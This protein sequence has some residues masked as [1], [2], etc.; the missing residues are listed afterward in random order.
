MKVAGPTTLPAL[1]ERAN[2]LIFLYANTS[3]MGAVKITGTAL[4]NAPRDE[5]W[6]ALDD[7]AVLVR[8]IPGRHGLE[9]V[10]PDAYRMTIMAAVASIKGTYQGDGSLIYEQK[11]VLV[12][13][14]R[15]SGAGAPGTVRTDVKVSL[16]EHNGVTQL[17]LRRRRRGGGEIGRV[18]QRVLSGV[19][20]KTAAEFFRAVEHVLTGKEPA[21]AAKKDY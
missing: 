8:T 4:L 15:A 1:D 14:R 9:E 11:P 17:G 20:K 18:G 10:G 16:A 2:A 3:T 5:V 6:R 13:A 19:A 21:P 7:P 12:R